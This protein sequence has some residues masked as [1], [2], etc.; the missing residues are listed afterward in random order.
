M[1]IINPNTPH[2]LAKWDPPPYLLINIGSFDIMS[3]LDGIRVYAGSWNLNSQKSISAEELAEIESATVTPSKFGLSMCFLLVKGGRK[4]VPLSR[5]S[6]LAEG[7]L[8]KKESIQILTLS[9][10][11]EED[12]IRV[13]GSAVK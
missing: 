1:D 8:V 12:I 13:D 9:K 2:I 6:S 3:F 10:D 4:Y 11:G 7:D 5:D